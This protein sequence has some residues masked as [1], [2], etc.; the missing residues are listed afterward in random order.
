[1]E[2]GEPFRKGLALLGQLLKAAVILHETH[3]CVHLRGCQNSF[4]GTM[5][6]RWKEGEKK[7]KSCICECVIIASMM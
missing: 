6:G 7:E 3:K 1:M 2:K 5:T 4:T